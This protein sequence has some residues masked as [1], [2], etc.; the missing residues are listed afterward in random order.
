MLQSRK[1]PN[2]RMILNKGFWGGIGGRFEDTVE[3]ILLYSK[4]QQK[5]FLEKNR[6]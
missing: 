6:K 4:S 1:D 3:E 2:D 5:H